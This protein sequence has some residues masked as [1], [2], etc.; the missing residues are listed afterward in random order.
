MMIKHLDHVWTLIW[1]LILGNL[2]A[3]A[4]LLVV[5][6]WVALLTFINGRMLVP[7][8]LV[9]IAIGCFVS[10]FQWQNLVVLVLFSIIGYADL[11]AGWPR[12]PFVI[13]FVLGGQ[14]ESSLSQALQLFGIGFVTRPI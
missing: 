14:A 9:F 11:R 7:F 8:I 13:G 1:A 12:A 6:R 4:I 2:I 3:V 5:A 10:D